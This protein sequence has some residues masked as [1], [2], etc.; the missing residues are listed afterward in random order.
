MGFHLDDDDDDDEILLGK[1]NRI[2]VH[3]SDTDSDL[4]FVTD[5]KVRRILDKVSV[6]VS[7]VMLD[8][9]KLGL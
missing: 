8:G 5:M 1:L 6:Q 7:V 4:V 3:I 2:L 9:N